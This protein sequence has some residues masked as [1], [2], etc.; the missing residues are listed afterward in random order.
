MSLLLYATALHLPLRAA[1]VHMV[2]T[3]PPYFGLRD[4]QTGTW[5]GGDPTC[6]HTRRLPDLPK[7]PA[8]TLAGRASNQNYEREPGFRHVC[9][10]CGAQR[11]DAQLG[12]DAQHDCLA[13][14][15]GEAP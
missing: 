7:D 3:S 1:S 4:Y 6:P 13:W 5:Q 10:L 2:L 8:S 15:R 9:G 14:A 11:V 12:M